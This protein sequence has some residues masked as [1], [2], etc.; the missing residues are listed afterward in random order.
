MSMMVNEINFIQNKTIQNKTIQNKTINT[1]NLVS[2]NLVSNNL[3]S[4]NIENTN[5]NVSTNT[6]LDI[7]LIKKIIKTEKNN[8]FEFVTPS[9]DTL[10]FSSSISEPEY[11]NR[12]AMIAYVETADMYNK[13]TKKSINNFDNKW[14]YNIL[15]G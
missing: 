11:K 2:N 7:D 15:N 10:I 9:G 13:Y 3:V 5:I 14:I 12:K 6:L 4:D 8:L 1:D